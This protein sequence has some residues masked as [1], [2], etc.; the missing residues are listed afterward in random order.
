MKLYTVK[1]TEKRARTQ[2]KETLWLPFCW[3]DHLLNFFTATSP[4]AAP[5]EKLY[6]YVFD[7]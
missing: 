6:Q 3:F 5:I 1:G 7:I 4:P 2:N